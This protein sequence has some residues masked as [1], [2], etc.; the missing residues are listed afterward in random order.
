MHLAKS[1]CLY[2]SFWVGPK[3]YYI[4]IKECNYIHY[5]RAQLMLSL[6]KNPQFFSVE[7]EKENISP[8]TFFSQFLACEKKI[9]TYNASILFEILS[10]FIF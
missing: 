5:H 7:K 1:K 9:K 6:K 8:I 4:E 2:N 10:N 3:L